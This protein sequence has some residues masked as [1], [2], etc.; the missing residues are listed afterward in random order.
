MPIAK[1]GAE[2]PQAASPALD[3]RLVGVAA[4]LLTAFAG[5]ATAGDRGRAGGRCMAYASDSATIQGVDCLNVGSHVRV[6]AQ[7]MQ[8]AASLGGGAPG[9]FGGAAPAAM[10]PEPTTRLRMTP[11][12]GGHLFAR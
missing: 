7:V 5:A 10:H 3:C 8:G 1:P 11:G 2:R 4:I 6:E 12:P 9:L